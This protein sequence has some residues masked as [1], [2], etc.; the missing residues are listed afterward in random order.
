MGGVAQ[1]DGVVRAFFELMQARDWAG[2]AEL[3]SPTLHI[4]FTETG[5]Q[6]DGPEFLAMN[7][8][9]PEG[10]S[11]EVV[12]T[13]SIADRVAAQVRVEHSGSVFWCAGFYTVR[14]GVIIDGTE[15]WVAERS[16]RPPAWRRPFA[17]N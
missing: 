3:L 1:H 14:D 7:R 12:E 5:E 15:H 6:F 2:A 17:S 4:E 8:A 9:Y 10:W 11:I 16:Q 13:I